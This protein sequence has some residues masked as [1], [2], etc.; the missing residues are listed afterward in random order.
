MSFGQAMKRPVFVFSILLVVALISELVL[1]EGAVGVSWPKDR[2]SA[3]SQLRVNV[4]GTDIHYITQNRRFT[5]VNDFLTKHSSRREP[6]ILREAFYSDLADGA[7]GP[8]EATV[9]VEA[10]NGNK[11][12]WSFRE[13]GERGD[14]VTDELYMVTN[15]GGGEIGNTYT[16]FSLTDGTKLRT[17][18][19]SQL[20]TGELEAL[21]RLVLK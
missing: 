9:A 13:P 14:V 1:L 5:V 4:K 16:Y 2:Y 8:P 15:Y 11:V 19:Y 10:I 21:D 6:L 20:S 17:K 12:I 3:V 18:R 7:E